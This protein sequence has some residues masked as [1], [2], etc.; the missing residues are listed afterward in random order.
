LFSGPGIQYFPIPGN[1]QGGLPGPVAQKPDILKKK[2]RFLGVLKFY[3]GN[4][5][6]DRFERNGGFSPS[7]YSDRQFKNVKL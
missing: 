1:G 3:P 4:P 6:P 7:G 5:S 2:S